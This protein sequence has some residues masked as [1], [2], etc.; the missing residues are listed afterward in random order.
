MPNRIIHRADLIVQQI[1][2]NPTTDKDFSAPNFLY[3]DLKDTTTTDQWKPIYTDLN[4]GSPY[5]PD[6][7]VSGVPYYPESGV[8]LSYFNG[9][10]KDATDK[11]GNAI[12]YYNINITRYI[13][14]LV[15]KHTPNYTLRLW[16]PAFLYYPQMADATYIGYN[17]SLARGRVK[18]GSGTN[19]NYKMVLRIIYSNL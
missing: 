14:Q 5:Y 3:V 8:D 10:A 12:K 6:T 13:Q 2:D 9:Y 19:A 11:F 4:P 7:R 16:A 18:V 15:T 17:N 1:P